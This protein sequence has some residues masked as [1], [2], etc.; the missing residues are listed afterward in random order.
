VSD[1]TLSATPAA[2]QPVAVAAG[3][4]EAATLIELK[5]LWNVFDTDR[6]A[7]EKAARALAK[8]QQERLRDF[9]VEAYPQA[10]EL[11]APINRELLEKLIRDK[12]NASP[13]ATD[14]GLLIQIAAL[15]IGKVLGGVTTPARREERIGLLYRIFRDKGW[16]ADGLAEKI[17]DAKGTT[18]LIEADVKS[19]QKMDG[20]DQQKQLAKAYANPAKELTVPYDGVTATE[21]GEWRLALVSIHD[22][23]LA[24][25]QLVGKKDDTATQKAMADYAVVSLTIDVLTSSIANQSSDDVEQATAIAA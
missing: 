12:M 5:R 3:L 18:K 14:A 8:T 20:P 2:H 17:V 13:R 1:L 22:G 21:T 9:L 7:N 23:K 16:K 24:V 4:D 15:Q 25:R 6:A 19:R 10:L 11:I